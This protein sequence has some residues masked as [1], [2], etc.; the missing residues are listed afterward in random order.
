MNALANINTV[1]SARFTIQKLDEF[2]RYIAKSPDI[3][4]LIAH[5]KTVEEVRERLPKIMV[6]LHEKMDTPIEILEVGDITLKRPNNP[7]YSVFCNYRFA[8]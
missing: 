3:P 6:R 8:E 7:D 1:F 5:G 4:N 2:E